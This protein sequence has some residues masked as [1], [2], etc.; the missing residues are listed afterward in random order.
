MTSAASSLEELP[1]GS[2]YV[3]MPTTR[4]PKRTL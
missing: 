3:Q 4:E 1:A 2:V